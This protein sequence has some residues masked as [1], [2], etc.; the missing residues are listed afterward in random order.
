MKLT[1]KEILEIKRKNNPGFKFPERHHYVPA[2]LLSKYS[3]K[4]ENPARKSKV[5][6]Y[7]KNQLKQN[8]TL[9]AVDKIYFEKNIYNF[10]S[11]YEEGVFEPDYLEKLMSKIEKEYV[12]FFEKNEIDGEIKEKNQKRRAVLFLVS[13]FFRHPVLHGHIRE[14]YDVRI[15]RN[16]DLKIKK[17]L[18]KIIFPN[19]ALVSMLNVMF[20]KQILNFLNDFSVKIIPCK[21]D[22]FCFRRCSYII[23]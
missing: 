21:S 12:C 4:I 7:Y 23:F 19:A 3:N 1:K 11:Y 13:L 8:S 18:K 22:F 16:I 6:V 5:A 14:S 2:F 10:C 17:I 20:N 15:I 9:V